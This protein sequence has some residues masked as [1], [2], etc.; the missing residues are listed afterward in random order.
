MKPS[1]LNVPKQIL[2]FMR[3]KNISLEEL[4]RRSGLAITDLKKC[5]EGK[6]GLKICQLVCIA[7][8][9]N[10]N[11]DLLFQENE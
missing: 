6:K 1:A 3:E 2:F 5:L 9:M 7:K 11:I 10:I 4:G 8:A